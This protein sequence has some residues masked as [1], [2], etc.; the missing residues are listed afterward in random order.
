M[1]HPIEAFFRWIG[2]HLSPRYSAMLVVPLSLLLFLPLQYLAYFKL[3]HFAMDN[4]GSISLAFFITCS[5]LIV[6]MVAKTCEWA[7]NGIRSH[8]HKHGIRKYIENAPTDQM[9]ILITYAQSQ[10]SSL[11]FQPTNG[12]VCDL[13]QRGILYRSSPLGNRMSG[14]PYSIHPDAQIF[15]RRRT[16]QKILLAHARNESKS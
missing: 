12:A 9:S 14:F 7:M 6:S 10:K 13:E 4:R 3:D 15:L 1:G 5:V 2:T 16:F 8:R 11:M